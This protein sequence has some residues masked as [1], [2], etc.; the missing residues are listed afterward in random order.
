MLIFMVVRKQQLL[1]GNKM[2]VMINRLQLFFQW[3][4]A[5]PS[6]GTSQWTGIGN[7]PGRRSTRVLS[8][9]IVSFQGEVCS[10]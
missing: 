7:A 5:N 6:S 10:L 2:W 9:F 4:E 1:S 8:S 3:G